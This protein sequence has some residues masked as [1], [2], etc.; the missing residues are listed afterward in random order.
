MHETS[1]GP[2]GIQAVHH[3]RESRE[4]AQPAGEIKLRN[5]ASSNKDEAG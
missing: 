4:E 3:A 1:G 2:G 5:V